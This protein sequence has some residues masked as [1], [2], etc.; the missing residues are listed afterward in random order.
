MKKPIFVFLSVL[1][2]SQCKSAFVDR[3]TSDYFPMEASNEWIYVSNSGDTVSAK[4]INDTLFNSDSVWIYEFLGELQMLNKLPEA[5]FKRFVTTVFRYGQEIAVEDRFG[6]FMEI[7]P[8]SGNT[9]AETFTN[10]VV[11]G[12]DS[13]SL[14]R[15]ISGRADYI[16]QFSVENKN[17]DEVYRVSVNN[18]WELISMGGTVVGFDS[19]DFYLAPNIGPVMIYKNFLDGPQVI[20]DTFWLIRYSLR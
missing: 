10:T 6:L 15:N 2:L 8:V 13:I 18:T 20:R 4:V 19:L 3:L 14:K 17:Y 7:P 16:G 1:L 11:L 5:I 12:S 9:W